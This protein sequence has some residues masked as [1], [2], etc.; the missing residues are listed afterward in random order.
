MTM[1][2]IVLVLWMIIGVM[3]FICS[4]QGDNVEWSSYW[5]AYFMVIFALMNNIGE[6]L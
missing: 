5:L 6:I 3:Q 2:I 1:I 4:M